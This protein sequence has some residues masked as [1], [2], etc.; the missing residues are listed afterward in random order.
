M[1]IATLAHVL[2]SVVQSDGDTSIRI[3]ALR[4]AGGPAHNE[5]VQI[6]IDL[7]EARHLITI[8]EAVVDG[9]Q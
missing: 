2:V 8:L 5:P 1:V 3:N 6:R 7:Q 4:D 9:R